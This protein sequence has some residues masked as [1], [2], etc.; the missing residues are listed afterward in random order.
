L[1]RRDQGLESEI[2]TNKEKIQSL[3]LERSHASD[4]K[5][6]AMTKYHLLEAA[7][8]KVATQLEGFEA[9]MK[10]SEVHFPFCRPF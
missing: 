10:D 6:E 3:A 9:Q 5:K 2:K 1:V 8:R 4:A 7:Y